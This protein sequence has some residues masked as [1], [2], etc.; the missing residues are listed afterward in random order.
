VHVWACEASLVLANQAVAEKSN[1]I[2]AI[3]EVLALKGNQGRRYEEVRALLEAQAEEEASGDVKGEKDSG[4]VETRRVWVMDRVEWIDPKS[5]F[6]GLKTLA[7]VESE[8]EIVGGKKSVE[9]RG[10]LSSLPPEAERLGQKIRARWGVENRPHRGL[11]M[12]FNKDPCR[13][14][15]GQAVENIALIRRF[16]VNL[17][18]PPL[19]NRASKT[20]AYAWLMTRTTEISSFSAPPRQGRAIALAN[21]RRLGI[22]RLFPLPAHVK[23]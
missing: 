3:P 7:M 17:L 9:R 8:R 20:N 18:T 15:S 14:R 13:I 21:L 11:D 16:A 4:R 10:F 19:A 6:P 1:E 2:T 5:T 12:A 22:M 23:E